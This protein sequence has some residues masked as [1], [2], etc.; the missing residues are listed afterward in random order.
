[1]LK[2]IYEV[3]TRCFGCHFDYFLAILESP[4]G[5]QKKKKKKKTQSREVTKLEESKESMLEDQLFGAS[6]VLPQIKK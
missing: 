5:L 6:V 2:I 4:A 1:M 3:F